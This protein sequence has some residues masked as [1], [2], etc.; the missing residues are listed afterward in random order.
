MPKIIC[1]AIIAIPIFLQFPSFG[2]NRFLAEQIKQAD[3]LEVL[4]NMNSPVN[5]CIQ[6]GNETNN[7]TLQKICWFHKLYSTFTLTCL[8]ALKVDMCR[9]MDSAKR[10]LWLVWHNNDPLAAKIGVFFRN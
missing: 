10:P 2:F 8:G 3:F 5:P 4:E 1:C 7:F 9:I 6:L